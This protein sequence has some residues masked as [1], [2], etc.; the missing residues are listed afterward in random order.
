[1]VPIAG[2]WYATWKPGFIEWLGPGRSHRSINAR[3]GPHWV[4][5]TIQPGESI[6][7]ARA[8][9]NGNVSEGVR[10]ALKTWAETHTP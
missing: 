8:A 4:S 9:G 1:M 6:E 10:T 5:P 7:R 3:S 2:R